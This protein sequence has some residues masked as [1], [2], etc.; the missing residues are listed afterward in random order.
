[1]IYLTFIPL[2][3][4][5]IS[6]LSHIVLDASQ[7]S[8]NVACANIEASDE[9]AYPCSLVKSFTVRQ[10]RLY[11]KLKLQHWIRNNMDLVARKTSGFPYRCNKTGLL[12]LRCPSKA[13]T[14]SQSYENTEP[15]V[16]SYF[17]QNKTTLTI[18]PTFIGRNMKSNVIPLIELLPLKWD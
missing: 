3:P 4:L 18:T 7:P 6:L 17:A 8:W 5:H 15:Y 10:Y 13:F 12:S 11:V 2:S 16:F 14:S 9:P 1:M